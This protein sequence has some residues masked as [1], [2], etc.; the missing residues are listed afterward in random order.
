MITGANSG[1]GKSVASQ[2]AERGGT[3]HLVC[4]NAVSAEEARAEIKESTG[5]PV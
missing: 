1:I 4:R 2:V 3:V 5:N